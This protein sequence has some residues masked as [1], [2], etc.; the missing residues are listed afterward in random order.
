MELID[1][2]EVFRIFSENVQ[3]KRTVEE[4]EQENERLRKEIQQWVMEIRKLERSES[5]R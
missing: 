1:W 2:D 4:L 3:L 5:G